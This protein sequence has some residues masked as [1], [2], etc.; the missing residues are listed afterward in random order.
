MKAISRG[1]GPRRRARPPGRRHRPDHPEAVPQADRAHRVRAVPVLRLALRRGRHRASRLR[2]QPA[3]SSRGARSCSPAAT[4]A[5]ARRASTPPG[6]CRTTGSTSSS[7]RRSATSSARTPGRSGWSRSRCPTTRS[8]RLMET[9]D[10]D[11]GSELTVDLERSVI[12]APDGREVPFDVRRVDALPAPE[13]PRRHRPDARSTRTTITAYE[14][15]RLTALALTHARR[16]PPRRRDRA[17]RWRPRRSGCSTRSGSS[18]PSTRSAATRS[19]RRA[20]RSPTRRSRPAARPTPCCSPRSACPSSKGKPVRPEQGLLGL[21]KELGVYANLRPA[22][23]EGI[24]LHDRARARRR[25]LLRR[26]GHP[27]GRHLVR[28]VRVH[29]TRGRA[30]RPA[31]LR[32]RARRGAGG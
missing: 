28:H 4:S 2:A 5:A 6:R 17:R 7:R 20:R 11:R 25:P 22:R 19:S 18:T 30:D 32:D 23:A 12:V 16:R 1:D 15:E 14:R 9:V 29:A 27:R 24:D 26:E 8:K 3:P 31:R 13:R 21:R 10:L